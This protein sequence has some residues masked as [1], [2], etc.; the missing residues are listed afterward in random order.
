VYT[1]EAG[2]KSALKFW[3]LSIRTV[4]VA[5]SSS[6][7]N[8]FSSPLYTPNSLLRITT[9]PVSLKM[10]PALLGRY[11]RKLPPTVTSPNVGL[12][13]YSPMAWASTERSKNRIRPR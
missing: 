5:F 3:F 9:S 10:V 12:K 8:F 6:F 2:E 11:W 4:T 13:R 1:N 7:M